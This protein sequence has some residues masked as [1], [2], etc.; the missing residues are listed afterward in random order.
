SAIAGLPS[1]AK[2]R[3]NRAIE[4]APADIAADIETRPR[5]QWW[6]INRRRCGRRPRR[7][8][9]GPRTRERK[10]AHCKAKKNIPRHHFHYCPLNDLWSKVPCL[11]PRYL[12]SLTW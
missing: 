11:A 1:R 5:E 7:Q 8:I 9:S 10:Q 12:A 2:V 3:V 4:P 6:H